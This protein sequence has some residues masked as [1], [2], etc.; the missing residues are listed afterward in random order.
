VDTPA[1][2][3]LL[4]QFGC[5]ILSRRA[6]QPD[7]KVTLWRPEKKTCAEARVVWRRRE[8]ENWFVLAL[9]FAEDTDFWGIDFPSLPV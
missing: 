2:T 8:P 1:E 3:V 7:A 9:E 4:S 6:P 5:L